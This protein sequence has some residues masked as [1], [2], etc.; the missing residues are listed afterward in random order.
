[1]AQRTSILDRIPWEQAYTS[2]LALEQRK[3]LLVLGGLV[4]FLLMV[5]LLPVSCASRKLGKLEKEYLNS[6]KNLTIL[7]DKVK[8]TK[9][10]ETQLRAIESSLSKNQ[11]A[12]IAT[13]LENLAAEVGISKNINSLKPRKI[14]S[15]EEFEVQGL[16]VRLSQISLPAVVDYLSKIENSDKI[17]MK[18]SKLQIKPRYSNRSELDVTFQVSTIIPKG[19][20]TELAKEGQ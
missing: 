1:M 6:Q 18:V 10:L 17:T 11:N 14:S 12:S 2:F 15:S 20:T 9:A 3:Q 4:F 19:K 8:E 5:V 13:V 16:D 7:A